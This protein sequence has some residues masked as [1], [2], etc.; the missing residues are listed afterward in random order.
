MK[1]LRIALAALF[2]SAGIVSAQVSG[3][4][5]A[6]KRA[7]EAGKLA[8]A[9]QHLQLALQYAP[10]NSEIVELLIEASGDDLGSRLLW[11]HQIAA[12]TA[13]EAGRVKLT[14]A[15]KKALAKDSSAATIASARAAAVRELVSFAQRRQKRAGR[16]PAEGLVAAWARSLAWE[17]ARGYPA[18]EGTLIGE[19]P[20]RVVVEKGV[21]EPVMKA[22]EKELTSALAGSRAG[23][24]LE[25]ARAL[26]GFAAQAA[27][28][29]LQGP[30]PS[31]MEKR[32]T[33]A[34]NAM[35]KARSMM[36]KAEDR[37]WT[38]EE[39]EWLS[40][41]EGESFTRQ[42]KSFRQPAV[43]VSPNGLYRI[44]TDC[45]MQTLL[46]V[47]K[48]IELHHQRLVNFF[49]RDPF[50]GRQGIVR[51]VPEAWG[52]EAEGAGYWWAGGFQ[53]GDTTTVRFSCGTIEGLG[54][55]LTHE[56][57]HR[58]DGAI[59]PGQPAWLV[60][61]KAV[62][63]A[64]A[65]GASDE[66]EFVPNHAIFGTL[67]SAYIKGFGGENK[68]T[69]LVKG[70]PEDYRDNYTA[71][72]ALYVYLNTWER[73]GKRLYHDRLVD[74]MSTAAKANSDPVDR[75]VA[76]FA[77][78]ADGRPKGMAAFAK[79]F[80]EFVSGFYWRDPKPH[81]ERYT[82]EVEAAEDDFVLDEPTWVWSWN[83][84]EPYFGTEQARRAGEILQRLGKNTAAMQ[85]YA[86][87]LAVDGRDPR[88]ET[89]IL[90]LLAETGDDDAA[91]VVE[92]KLAGTFGEFD[93]EPPFFKKLSKTRALLAKLAEV[94]ARYRE[95]KR[96]YVAEV[97]RADR[98]RLERALGT[99]EPDAE[100][101]GGDRAT[102]THAFEEPARL[103]TRW[104]EDG[105]TGYEDLRAEGYWGTTDKGL[106]YVG[107]KGPRK[108]TG[109]FDRR[110]RNR[111]AFARSEDWISPGRYAI[112]G[113]IRFSTVFANACFVLGWTRRDQNV[114]VSFSGGDY[115]FAIGE[116]E[117]EPKFEEIR[118]SFDGLRDRDGPLGA[119]ERGT[120]RFQQPSPSFEFEFIVDGSSVEAWFD[121]VLV[122]SYHTIDGSPIQ[123]HVG[124]ATSYGA[125]E[126]QAPI[127]ER[128]DR[129][130]HLRA[131]WS[132]PAY[133]SVEELVSRSFEDLVNRSIRGLPESPNGTVLV[134]SPMPWRDEDP[135]WDPEDVYKR[136]LGG[137]RMIAR[138]LLRQDAT[139]PFLV[140]APALLGEEKLRELADE[141][142][143]LDPP[144]RLLE[145]AGTGF[146]PEGMEDSPDAGKRWV[147][148]V[149][150]FGTVRTC[151]PIFGGPFQH[152]LN[153]WLDVFRDFGE[154]ERELPEVRR[155][156]D[157]E[158]AEDVDEE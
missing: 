97:F 37:P 74:Y 100:Y 106:L 112:R 25:L 57:T 21:H 78:G 77:D 31:G 1:R 153:L 36:A 65:Y 17:V 149:D 51:V 53:G 27:F 62:W 110:A 9:A 59:F 113:R 155:D 86:W 132:P 47:A 85:A 64:A 146:T 141:L 94:E 5:K 96:P 117:E 133:G 119:T 83:R 61:G 56:L 69:D 49:G 129:G 121:G 24:A 19:P 12:L 76:H 114:R 84:A 14:G 4:L 116:S 158:E 55:T 115:L 105:L 107:S 81:A 135:E 131:P 145:H 148:F 13:D 137:A 2:V 147:L 7:L 139:Q 150:P 29:D 87:A 140:A 48:T 102:R 11:A 30:K 82:Q 52:L 127:V 45:G 136:A 39:L 130:R 124:F 142:R 71:G 67:E 111:H 120:H 144:A 44:E 80:G 26:N 125:I 75:F 157:D 156:G 41:E 50:D 90:P 63:T 126:V 38:V 15:A 91:W 8:E 20:P 42:H 35:R 23:D 43:A 118:W 143:E 32:R 92:R 88:T 89:R 101:S 108:G 79:A 18:I 109:K 152:E 58:F 22:L 138:V 3:P 104:T 28:D 123:G 128:L 33:A 73:S 46:G 60:E 70:E 93:R 68:L 103:V 151:T 72:Y 66:E 16:T 154:P 40:Q 95:A 98:V 122:G 99:A 34:Q 10:E 54:H 6:G 134:W